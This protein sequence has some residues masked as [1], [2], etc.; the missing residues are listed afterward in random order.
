MRRV[1]VHLDVGSIAVM[2]V[3]CGLF[4]VALVSKGF[5]HDLLLE[6]GV[7]LVSVKL[8]IM[9]H[10]NGAATAELHAMLAE[11]SEA[12]RRLGAMEEARSA[13]AAEARRRAAP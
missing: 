6:A 12:V 13:P 11:V 1:R 3:T 2:V 5:T 10:K 4:V 9:A 7:F 8:M